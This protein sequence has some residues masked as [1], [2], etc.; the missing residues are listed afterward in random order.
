VK[1]IEVDFTGMAEMNRMLVTAL[2]GLSGAT[3]FLIQV[4]GDTEV[5]TL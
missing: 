1:A 3:L 5:V 4:N 2:A